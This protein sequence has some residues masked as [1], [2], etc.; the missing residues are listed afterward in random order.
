PHKW[1]TQLGPLVSESQRALI[2]KYVA[3]G[4]EE[5]A[6]LTYGGKRLEGVGFEQGYF[7][8]PTIFTDVTPQMRIAREEVFGP[9]LCIIPFETEREAIEI[10]NDVE[11]GLAT[12]VWTRDITRGHRVAQQIE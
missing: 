2:E 7:Y 10:A 8:M 12:S 6:K 1:E 9:V 4:K 11:F 3:I 5:G